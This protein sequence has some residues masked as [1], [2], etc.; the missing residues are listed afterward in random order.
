VAATE[1][2]DAA[3]V[4]KGIDELLPPLCTAPPARLS[5]SRVV[6]AVIPCV[7]RWVARWHPPPAL[8]V[9]L[10]RS[11]RVLTLL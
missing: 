9:G 11:W 7:Q 6:G 5:L 4:Q 1:H 8:G 2:R 3:H 10:L